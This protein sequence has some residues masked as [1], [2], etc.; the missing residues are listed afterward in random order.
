[1]GGWEKEIR[2]KGEE[3]VSEADNGKEVKVE[4][5]GVI[6]VLPNALALSTRSSWALRGLSS[7]S[8]FPF[9]P[10]SPSIPSLAA[11]LVSVATS[12]STST[13][14]SSTLSSLLSDAAYLLANLLVNDA[15]TSVDEE[16]EEEEEEK[17]E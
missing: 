12:S 17:E 4:V 13:S 10:L 6:R 7:P 14:S 2:I 15:N 5:N 9:P 1:M 8:L 11:D 3:V 16:K